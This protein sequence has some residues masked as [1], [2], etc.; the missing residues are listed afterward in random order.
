MAAGSVLVVEDDYQVRAML[1]ATMRRYGI[2]VDTAIDGQ[3]AI[4]KIRLRTTYKVIILDLMMP[5]IDGFGVVS[6]LRDTSN[7]A[8]VIVVSA[9][10]SA[11]DARLDRDVVKMIVKKPLDLDAL[12]APILEACGIDPAGFDP[13]PVARL[14]V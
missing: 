11:D 13:A 7:P 14:L 10:A 4:D 9:V 1:A 8:V 3:D 6:Y 12:M 5:K 2:E